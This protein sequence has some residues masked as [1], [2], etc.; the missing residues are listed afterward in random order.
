M[1]PYYVQHDLNWD[2]MDLMLLPTDLEVAPPHNNLK[3]EQDY[4]NFV[5]L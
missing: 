5:S 3:F 2:L 1:T 4:V